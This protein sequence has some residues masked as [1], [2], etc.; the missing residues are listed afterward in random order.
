VAHG[1]LVLSVDRWLDAHAPLRVVTVGRVTLSRPVAALLRRPAVRLEAVRTHRWIESRPNVA[2][3]WE[4]EVLQVLGS[5]REDRAR[6]AADGSTGSGVSSFADQWETAGEA[7][8]QA[9]GGHPDPPGGRSASGADG[10]LGLDVAQVLWDV[11][12]TGATLFVGSSNSCRD[13]DITGGPRAAPLTVVA[14]R[15]LAGID[16]CVSTAVGVALSGGGPMFAWMGDLT[17]LHD[18]NGLL[19][20]PHEPRPDLTIVVTNDDGG[21][22]FTLLEPGEPELAGDFERV[23]ATPTGADLAAVCAAHGVEHQRV[24]SA[25]ELRRVVAQLP[26]G[27][28]VV[29]VPVDR[30]GHRAGHA[31]LRELARIALR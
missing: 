3:V 12:P 28:R 8:D 13:L 15:G 27:I 21:G 19:I 17:F 11:I 23:F 9:L 29:E 26:Q 25:E 31:H 18:A 2:R 4:P 30:G 10:V 1:P 5:R 7:V 22:I 20:G 24:T 14:S 16:G 6:S